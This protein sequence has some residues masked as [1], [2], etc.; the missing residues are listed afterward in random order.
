MNFLANLLDVAASSGSSS[1]SSS[2]GAQSGLPTWVVWVG[3]LAVLV[4]MFVVNYF[5]RKKQQKAAEEKMNSMKPGDKV[6]TIGLI[7][8]TVVS[9][10]DL[11]NTL[12]I[13]TGEGENVSYLTI[14]KNAVYQ[15]FPE[16][17]GVNGVSEVAD[18]KPFEEEKAD[19]QAAETPAEVEEKAEENEAA[20]A[21]EEKAEEKAEE[22]KG[23]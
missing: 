7:C 16:G 13:E 17:S 8:G 20:E 21:A 9:V 2:S 4:I 18:E 23:E 6:K 3:L 14:D 10:N 22:E 15:T 19:E 12:V 5:S 1:G 11:H